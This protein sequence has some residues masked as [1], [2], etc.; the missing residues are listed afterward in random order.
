MPYRSYR[1]LI[2]VGAVI[3]TALMIGNVY[4]GILRVRYGKEIQNLKQEAS[5]L[6]SEVR[7]LRGS[8]A[9]MTS[10]AIIEERALE[11]GMIYPRKL[12]RTLVVKVDADDVPATWITRDENQ[13][14]TPVSVDPGKLALV[15][16]R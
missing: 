9:A 6:G 1:G 11:M 10:L 8:K 16:G 2:V 12:P 13:L 7:D 4:I 3:V 5:M 14:G 15:G